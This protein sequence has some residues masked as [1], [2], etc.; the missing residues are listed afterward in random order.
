M[1]L[2]GTQAAYDN[3]KAKE[4]FMKIMNDCKDV[5]KATDADIKAL[6]A[7]KL[8]ESHEGLC[9]LECMF[10]HSKM[11]KD[12]KFDKDS[13]IELSIKPL[14]GDKEKE[15]KVKNM[16]EACA[17]EIGAGDKDKCVN[18]K[19]IVECVEKKGKEFGFKWP[20]ED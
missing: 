13:A 10:D 12:G 20:G 16:M 19:T 9:L 8:P 18:A 14:N 15:A 17:T 1:V 3:A 7:K 2:N 6:M 11:M 5:V 4:N